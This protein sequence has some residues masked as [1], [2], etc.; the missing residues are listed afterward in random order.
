M[1]EHDPELMPAL[2]ALVE[3]DERGDPESP[4]RWT[5][6]SLRHLADE[7]TSQGHTVSAPTV[8]AL[9]RHNGFS[10]QGTRKTLEGTQHPDRDAQFRYINEQVK[11]HQ[12]AGEPVILASSR[13]VP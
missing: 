7:L 10:L 4:L 9:L 5:A 1:I 2:L 3:P 12:A 13:P 11:H 6:K 8:G